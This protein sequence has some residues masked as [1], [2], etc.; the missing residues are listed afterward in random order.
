MGGTALVPD[1]RLR[2]VMQL[3][4]A[5]PLVPGA[6]ALD[7]GMGAGQVSMWLHGR[8]LRVTGTGLSLDSYG[9][10][11]EI[12][13]IRTVEC[14]A[15]DLPFAVES[16]D[17]VVMSHVLEHCPNVA[18]ALSEARRVLRPGG[19]LLIFVPPTEAAV[20]AGHVSVGWNVGQLLYVLLASGFSVADGRFIEW[21][22]SVAAFVRKSAVA[23]PPLR[24][25]R[26]DINILNAAGLFPGS[27]K[28]TDGFDDGFCGDIGALNWDPTHLERLERTASGK[29][30]LLMMLV[31]LVPCPIFVARLLSVI[32]R[33]IQK[34]QRI[35][36][37]ALT[38]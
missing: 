32:A 24:G 10:G 16:F 3:L 31:R 15:D 35:N 13:S 9:L 5:A 37:S 33:T 2:G 27:V 7:V 21:L 11:P 1:R 19:M 38:S 23:L 36:P 25:D 34:S 4:E 29:H 12:A 26:G 22:G 8:G 30:R 20:A 18:A 17:F 6:D 28:S 14:P